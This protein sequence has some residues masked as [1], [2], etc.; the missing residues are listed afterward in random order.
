MTVAATAAPTRAAAPAL[1]LDQRLTLAHHEMDDRLATRSAAW[2][3]DT[4]HIP[5][6]A[7]ELLAPAPVSSYSTPVAA[8]LQE[9]HRLLANRGW[10]TRWL[11]DGVRACAK[12]AIQ[13][14]ARTIGGGHGD[15]AEEVLLDR[16]RAEQPEIQSI[17]SW[18]DA[19]AGPAPVLAMF[20]RAARHA[21]RR[22]I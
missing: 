17:G 2:A 21:D 10:C 11:S 1:T 15:Q 14:A 13:A 7:P 4:A 18:N 9:A 8:V 12:G 16:I 22:G 20:D 3:V 6:E 19:Q 5:L